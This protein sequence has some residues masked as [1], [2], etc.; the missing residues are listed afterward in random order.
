MGA[1][2]VLP[3]VRLNNGASLIAVVLSAAEGSAASLSS[4]NAGNDDLFRNQMRIV[5]TQSSYETRGEHVGIE[6]HPHESSP[7]LAR[8]VA[9]RVFRIS[10]NVLST[11]RC[12][13]SAGMLSKYD[14]N[15]WNLACRSD[16]ISVLLRHT[17]RTLSISP[18]ERTP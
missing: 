3:L 12:H 8:R 11:S 9:R 7:V 2:P 4:L 18:T 14:W 6:D 13:S 16:R 5:P 15:S 1:T 10:S 17:P